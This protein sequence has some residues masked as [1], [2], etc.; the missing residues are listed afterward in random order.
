MRVVETNLPGV[1]V[2]E[3]HAVR[4]VRG[5]L[6]ELWNAEGH[7]REALLTTCVLDLVTASTRGVIRGLHYQHP[8]GQAKLVSVLDG[9]VFDVA[10]DI[11]QGSATFGRWTCVYLGA[12]NRRQLFIPAGFAHGFAVLSDRAVLHYKLGEA[13]HPE[14]EGCVA[15]NDPE[16]RI[17][18]PIEAPVLSGRDAEA[19]CLA[20]VPEARLPRLGDYEP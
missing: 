12:E 10:V 13:Y 3:P 2:V 9:E 15:W 5:G 11:R 16:L 6:L 18:W 8:F 14:A 1:R 7:A 20:L 17:A 4:D 19:P